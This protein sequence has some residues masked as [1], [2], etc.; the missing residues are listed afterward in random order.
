MLVV[1][2]RTFVVSETGACH[3]FENR[4]TYLERQCFTPHNEENSSCTRASCTTLG[5]ECNGFYF[6]SRWTSIT[7]V[8][9]N[10]EQWMAST[11]W[12]RKNRYKTERENVGGARTHTYLATWRS[13]M[14]YRYG[15]NQYVYARCTMPFVARWNTRRISDGDN[16]C[17]FFRWPVDKTAV[18]PRRPRY[19]RFPTLRKHLYSENSN[20]K[21]FAW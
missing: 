2:L 6:Y 15:R 16:D 14:R 5:G 18:T 13:H 4:T 11:I 20:R 9:G 17:S 3:L 12:R 1:W 7:D 19:W 8:E 21:L 10:I